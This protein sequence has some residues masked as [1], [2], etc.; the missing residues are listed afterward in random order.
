M[1]GIKDHINVWTLHFK[2]LMLGTGSQDI[3]IP[4]LN[5]KTC[6]IQQSTVQSTAEYSVSEEELE[7]LQEVYTGSLEQGY[8]LW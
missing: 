4:P 1:N 3:R 2:T 7:I 5:R 6:W 8:F